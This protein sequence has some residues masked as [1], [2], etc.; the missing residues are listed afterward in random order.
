MEFFGYLITEEGTRPLPTCREYGIPRMVKEVLK[1][2]F[3]DIW[4]C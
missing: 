1:S 3:G 4:I 2:I